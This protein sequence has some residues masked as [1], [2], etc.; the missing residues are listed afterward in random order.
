MGWASSSDYQQGLTMKFLSK[1]DA[2]RFAEKQGWNYYVQEPKTKKFVKKAY[3]DN[4]L[5]SPNKLRLF[6]TK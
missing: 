5:Y 1:E 6:K 4:Y 2:I 3:A